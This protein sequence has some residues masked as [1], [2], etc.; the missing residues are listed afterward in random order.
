[1]PG[2]RM[3]S[4]TRG[5]RSG[6][7]CDR[8]PLPVVHRSLLQYSLHRILPRDM[9]RTARTDRPAAP[10]LCLCHRRVRAPLPPTL[11]A[12]AYRRGSCAVLDGQIAPPRLLAQKLAH[13]G[14]GR[15]IDGPAADFARVS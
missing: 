8:D 15:G 3:I 14:K 13:L 9:G 7:G 2:L 11:A 10:T 4:E 12:P 5:S 1:M 6:L